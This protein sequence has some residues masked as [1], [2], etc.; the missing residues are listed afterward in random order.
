MKEVKVKDIKRAI[1]TL[2]G[3]IRARKCDMPIGWR[4]GIRIWEGK[5]EPWSGSEEDWAFTK[6]FI[7]TLIKPYRKH[8]LCHF[9]KV[10]LKEILE[11]CISELLIASYEI[12]G[13]EKEDKE[14][15]I[16][17][18]KL[19]EKLREELEELREIEKTVKEAKKEFEMQMAEFEK[20]L[21]Q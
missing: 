21:P 7:I 1:K 17:Y 2:R 9:L 8:D 4:Y 18:E 14:L 16:W 6:G 20:E 13:I 15:Q 10:P 19:L 5:V 3:Q 12:R 11:D